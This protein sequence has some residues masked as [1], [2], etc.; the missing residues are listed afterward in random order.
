MKWF[1]IFIYCMLLFYMSLDV[2]PMKNMLDYFHFAI[3]MHSEK[4][5]QLFHCLWFDCVCFFCS[6]SSSKFKRFNANSLC[7]ASKSHYVDFS[8]IQWI[9]E[10]GLKIF[11][12]NIFLLGVFHLEHQRHFCILIFCIYV[13]KV[14]WSE[15]FQVEWS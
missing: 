12:S 13:T 11:Y 7:K 2:N 9:P 5:K 6:E 1:L 3:P 10:M 14:K 8:W 4:V 15:S